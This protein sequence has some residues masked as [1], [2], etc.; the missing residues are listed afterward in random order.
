MFVG[1]SHTAGI[2]VPLESSWT[3]IVS[4]SLKLKNYNLGV[5]GTSNDTAF[6]LAHYWIDRLHPSIVIFLSTE[7]TRLELHTIDNTVKDL[8]VQYIQN[9]M[10]PEAT[11]FMRHWISNDI[12]SDMN[13]LKNTLALQQLCNTRGIK[14]VQ[15]E[16]LQ[17]HTLDKARDLQHFGT[18]TNRRIAAMILSRL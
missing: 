10:F 13:Y 9:Q 1:C 4:T 6:R 15:E 16:A 2:G 7:K 14:Y 8:S 5:G 12:N 17:I 11:P 3:H 18:R